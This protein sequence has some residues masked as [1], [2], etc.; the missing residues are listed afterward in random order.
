MVSALQLFARI[1]Y[2]RLSILISS[3]RFLKDCDGKLKRG[4]LP[5]LEEPFLAEF[6]GAWSALEKGV[7]HEWH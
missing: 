1:R 3:F 2:A 5:S 6:Q 4:R 7:G